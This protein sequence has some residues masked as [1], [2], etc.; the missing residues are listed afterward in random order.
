MDYFFLRSTSVLPGEWSTNRN[1]WLSEA[2]LHMLLSDNRVVGDYVAAVAVSRTYYRTS[3]HFG[4]VP[5]RVSRGR[6]MRP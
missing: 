5:L 6:Q 1:S 3:G 4:R 2:L